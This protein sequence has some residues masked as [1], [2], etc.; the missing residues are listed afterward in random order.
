MNNAARPQIKSPTISIQNDAK[1]IT[2]LN[3]VFSMPSLTKCL[4][5][6]ALMFALH[7]SVKGNASVLYSYDSAAEIENKVMVMSY[8]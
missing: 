5:L 1:D 8:H 7:N 2:L 3:Q 6:L 4:K